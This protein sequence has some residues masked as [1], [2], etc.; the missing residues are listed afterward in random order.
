MFLPYLDSIVT[1][2]PNAF[3]R[4][5]NTHK[6]LLMPGELDFSLRDNSAEVGKVNIHTGEITAVSLPGILTEVGALRTAIDGITIGVI[7][8]ESLEVF[9]TKLSAASAASPLAQ[10]GVKWTV[11]YADITQFFDPPVNAIPNAGYQKIFTFT[12]PTADLTLLPTGT[13][14]LDLTVNPALAF[15]T[16]FEQTGRSPYGGRVDVLYIKYTD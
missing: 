15:V 12:I 13:E 5:P 14:E 16:A 9:N 1:L 8:S 11:G 4:R 10:R 3:Y 6:E 7:A 2:G